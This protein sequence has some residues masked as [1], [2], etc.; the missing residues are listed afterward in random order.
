MNRITLSVCAATII[1]IGSLAGIARAADE[2][3]LRAGAGLLSA[4]ENIEPAYIPSGILYD[5]VLPLSRVEE[6]DGTSFEPVSWRRWK[7]IV[8]EMQRAQSEGTPIA[9]QDAIDRAAASA[10]RGGTPVSGR[11]GEAI[12]VG[13]LNFTYDRFTENAF[14]SGAARIDGEVVAITRPSAFESRRAFAVAPARGRTY[15]GEQVVFQ[16]DPALF[17]TNGAAR[18]VTIDADFGD[19]AGE[20]TFDFGE[21]VVVRYGSVGTKTVRVSVSFDDGTQWSSA[22]LFDV[23]TLVAPLP[24]DTLSI[25][26]TIPYNGEFAGGE[27]YVYLAPAHSQITQPVVVIEGFDIDNSL[28]WDELYALLNDENLIEDARA[29]GFDL[30]VMN[31]ADATDYIQKNSLAVVELIEQ[32]QGVVSPG[33]TFPLIGASMGGLCGRYALSYMETNAIPH[34]ARTYISFDTPHNGASIPLGMQY[35]LDFFSGQ[36]AEAATLLASLDRP[37][38]RQ[39]LAYHHTTPPGATGASDSLRGAFDAELASLGDY[40]ATTRNVAV[41]NGSGAQAGQGFAAG[42]QVIF[43]EYDSFLVDIRGNVWAVPDGGPSQ[44]LQGE[45]NLILLPSDIM[46]VSVSGTLPYDNAPGGSRNSMAQMDATEAP[47]GD[48]IALHDDHCFIPTISALDLATSDLFY[49]IAG[50]QNLLSM[51]PFDAVY[52]PVANQPHVDVTTENKAWL[53]D[54]LGQMPTGVA[55]SSI[56]DVLALDQNVPNPFN[57]TTSISYFVREAGYVNLAVYDARGA[58]VTVLVNETRPAGANRTTWDGTNE[59]GEAAGSGVYFYR[60]TGQGAGVTRK[61]VLVK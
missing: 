11:F 55:G 19:G 51:T 49:D 23:I 61:M 44:I 9:G 45:I 57:P 13:I 35:W 53:L 40:P 38:A 48:I 31:F 58:R 7:Q 50:E 33:T 47:Y 52:F 37:A 15:R 46:D 1:A 24:N 39:M 22:F 8:H 32:V 28:N 59:R 60:L 36:S 18:P 4:L 42:D 6:H 25:T 26:A 41:A 21:E 34:S 20:R 10:S 5:R 17:L 14:E 54:E 29:Q 27:A 16:F 30:V 12:P 2:V 3:P 56:P 43:W